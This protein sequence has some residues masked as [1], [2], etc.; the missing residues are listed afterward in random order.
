VRNAHAAV[1]D[2]RDHALVLFGGATAW[3]DSGA[4]MGSSG[5]RIP[6]NTSGA[7]GGAPA[8]TTED[9]DPAPAPTE[10]AAIAPSSPE[11]PPAAA[12][13]MVEAEPDSHASV[14]SAAGYVAQVPS[15]ES[16]TGGDAPSQWSALL[17]K[18]P[19]LRRAAADLQRLGILVDLR[20]VQPGTLSAIVGPSFGTSSRDYNLGRLLAAYRATVEWDPSATIL[21]WKGDRRMGS[22]GAKGLTLD[23]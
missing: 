7:M 20:E 14:P 8:A 18:G 5:R 23:Q 22:F 1:Y 10:G 12:D 17:L 11:S 6:N 15:S 9:S 3:C 21:L 19:E 16:G 13:P 4:G 2:S